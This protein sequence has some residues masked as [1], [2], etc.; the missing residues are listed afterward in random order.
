MLESKVVAEIKKKLEEVNKKVQEI[1]IEMYKKASEEQAKNGGPAPEAE[2]APQ[3][4]NV[5]D[6]EFTDKSEEKKDKKKK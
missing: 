5:V 4:D 1:S 2:E 3:D 6:A